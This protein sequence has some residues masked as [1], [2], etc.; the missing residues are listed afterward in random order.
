MCRDDGGTRFP[1]GHRPEKLVPRR[2]FGISTNT[3]NA[4]CSISR[5]ATPR[6][7]IRRAPVRLGRGA[8][9]TG[10]ASSISSSWSVPGTSRTSAA[11]RFGIGSRRPASVRSRCSAAGVDDEDLYPGHRRYRD[12]GRSL[13]P[14]RCSSHQRDACRCPGRGSSAVFASRAGVRGQREPALREARRGGL[15]RELR[16]ENLRGWVAV[17]GARS[18][19][20]Q[21]RGG[22]PSS[23]R[24]DDGT[25]RHHGQTSHV[26]ARDLARGSSH[27]AQ[28]SARARSRLDDP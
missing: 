17:M 7:S 25:A 5:Q 23:W 21:A 16:V 11:G 3:S 28:R 20:E 2:P 19:S 14:L 8:R 27:H 1:D 4:A 26:S 18:H 12:H 13:G 22:G 24:A 6:R 9:P 15:R 10:R